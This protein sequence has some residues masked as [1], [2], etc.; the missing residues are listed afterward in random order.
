MMVSVWRY[1]H[2]L[3]A[4][5]SSAFL[6]M[7]S[8]TGVILAVEPISNKVQP[9]RISGADE[10]SL[11]EV[12]TTLDDTYEEILAVTRDRNGFIKVSAIIDGA[13]AEFYVNPFNGEKLADPIEKQAIY[14][15]A[16]NLHRSLFLKSTGRIL[17]GLSSF[18]LILIAISGIV[19]IAKRQGGYRHFF[20]PIVRENFSQYHHVV[21]SRFALVPIFILALT[22]VYLSL[23]R[24]NIIPETPIS[25]EVDYDNIKEEPALPHAEFELFK[26][27]QLGDIRDLEY[28]FSEFVEDYYIIRYRDKEV[29]LNQVTGDILAEEKF[30]MVQIISSWATVLHTAEGSILWAIFVGLGSLAIPFLIITGFVIYFKRPKTKIRNEFSKNQAE[31]VILVGT[32]GGT[33]LQF[34]EQ[35]QKKLLE[36]KVPCFLG[37][38][39]E[40]NRFKSMQQLI[41]ITAT[42]GQGE[43][44]ASA[45][46]FLSLLQKKP[47][48]QNFKFTT[49][50]FGSTAYPH[51]CQ[52]AHEAHQHLS[53]LDNGT[54]FMEVFTVND[55]SFEAF[56]NWCT[57][58]SQ[59]QGMDLRL[60]KPKT[61]GNTL[62]SS[63]FKVLNKSELPTD[64]TFLLN[65]KN[66]NGAKPIS[67]DLL[68]V[69]PKEGERERLYSLGKLSDNSLVVSIR[70]HPNGL[71]SNY[72]HQL[73]DGEKLTATVIPNRNFHF[74]KNSKKTILIA[75]GTG[76]GPFLGMIEE[77]TNKK[78]LH[79]YWGAR[80]PQSLNL[81]KEFIQKSMQGGKLSHFKTAYSREKEEKVY[82]QHLIKK[83]RDLFAQ[84]LKKRGAIMICGSIAMQKEV[85]YELQDICSQELG[86]DLSYFQNKKQIKMDCY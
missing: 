57:E 58:W 8:I 34:A 26:N 23:L 56:Q 86:R 49:V 9:Y 59:L 2:L 33:T 11:A 85:L 60:E 30:P 3:F 21:Y 17:I 78:E 39:N 47:Q 4:I 1:S 13:N 71:C 38:M 82:V 52:F 15:F 62:P 75:T 70:R 67:G 45:E 55:Q 25:M 10:L 72:L 51:F 20:S 14:Q 76:I 42:Y 79:L 24:F 65:L 35:F 29:F 80:T 68:S 32:E 66:L 43:A 27:T 83:D 77:N 61:M 64:E 81:Y 54:A 40:Y 16:T 46:K 19:L 37:M 69:V 48:N 53:Q 73:E 74:P 44:P 6:L 22:G 5:I 12:L 84:V 63:T 7:A 31:I 18:F 28:P 36:R 41:L 50:G